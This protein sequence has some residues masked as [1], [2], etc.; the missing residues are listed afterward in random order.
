MHG[1]MAWKHEPDR[2]RRPWRL[3]AAT[4]VL[5]G[6]ASVA[7]LII[8]SWMAALPGA[9]RSAVATYDGRSGE[10]PSVPHSHIR[11]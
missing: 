7:G 3:V 6:A 2:T 5:V 10:Q 4:V 1:T 11:F 9:N 8:F